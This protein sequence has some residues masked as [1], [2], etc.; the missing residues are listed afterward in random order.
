MLSGSTT[1]NG[2][3]DQTL[4]C[5]FVFEPFSRQNV[6]ILRI[7]GQDNQGVEDFRLQMLGINPRPRRRGERR[8]V[9]G[10]GRDVFRLGGRHRQGVAAGAARERPEARPGE[11]SAEAG[12]RGDGAGDGRGGGVDGVLRRLRRTGE[13]LGKRQE[14]RAR[15]GFEG[16]QA[17]GAVPHRSGDV[18]V[19]RFRG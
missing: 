5:R 8:R 1:Q 4:R 17:R 9:R 2:V 12:V 11:D 10:R 16:P 15:W 19:Q 14:L 18:S 13:L 3:M 7:V 6:F